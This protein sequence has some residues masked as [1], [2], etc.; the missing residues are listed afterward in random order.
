MED[1]N[2]KRPMTDFSEQIND[3]V[4]HGTY[5]YKFDDIGNVILNPSSSVFQEHYV[6]FNLRT[7]VYNDN[8]VKTFYNTEFVEFV[9]P[10]EQSV[11]QSV[12]ETQIELDSIKKENELLKTQLDSIIQESEQDGNRAVAIAIKDIILELRIS[13]GQG[14]TE[15]DFESEFPY[16]PMDIINTSQ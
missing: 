8:K 3:F 12:A 5:G 11:S 1:E 7:T 9:K 6:L 4:F 2:K 15:S 14:K 13:L 16:L 10:V